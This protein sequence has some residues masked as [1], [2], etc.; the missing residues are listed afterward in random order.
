M[1]ILYILGIAVIITALAISLW[2]WRFWKEA[3]E[4]MRLRY[5]SS[6]TRNWRTEEESELIRLE[7]NKDL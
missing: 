2:S 6:L 4:E 7:S 1:E 3:H 5:I